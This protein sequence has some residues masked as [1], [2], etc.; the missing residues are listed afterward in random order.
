VSARTRSGCAVTLPQPQRACRCCRNLSN[1]YEKSRLAEPAKLPFPFFI[2]EQYRSPC[3]TGQQRRLG[4][5]G[6]ALAV[7]LRMAATEEGEANRSCP[8][9]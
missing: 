1:R 6:S 3:K 9:P 4:G 7:V 2:D 8:V 5:C